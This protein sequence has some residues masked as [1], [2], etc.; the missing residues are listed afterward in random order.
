VMRHRVVLSYEAMSDN[1]TSDEIL[2][3]VLDRVPIPA[4]PL[5]T[6]VELNA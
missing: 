3:R 6:H 5:K 2:K 1:V 4:E